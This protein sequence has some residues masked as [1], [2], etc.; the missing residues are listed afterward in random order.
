MQENRASTHSPPSS[1]GPILLVA[2]VFGSI[3]TLV[4][5]V[6]GA[7]AADGAQWS[8]VASQ[9]QPAIA[10]GTLLT[11]GVGIT[12]LFLAWREFVGSDPKTS[13]QTRAD[14][15]TVAPSIHRWTWAGENYLDVTIRYA[16]KQTLM[17]CPSVDSPGACLVRGSSGWLTGSDDYLNSRTWTYRVIETASIGMLRLDVSDNGELLE[18]FEW[19]M[20]SL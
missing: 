2:I 8:V 16:G 18:T 9:M 20:S 10:L 13:R 5:L 11:A 6:Q 1:F 17:V 12:A 4:V 3:I 7:P 14:L 19:E 15:N